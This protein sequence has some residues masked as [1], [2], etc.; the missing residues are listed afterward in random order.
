MN[1]NEYRV[2]LFNINLSYIKYSHV[3]PLKN[4]LVLIKQMRSNKI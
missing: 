4:G 1:S 2:S 3:S